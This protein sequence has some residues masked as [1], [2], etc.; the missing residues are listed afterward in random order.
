MRITFKI[1]DVNQIFLDMILSFVKIGRV[2][3]LSHVMKKDAKDLKPAISVM[4][5]RNNSSI[6]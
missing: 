3:L 1:S 4:V 2:E 6:H 5:G